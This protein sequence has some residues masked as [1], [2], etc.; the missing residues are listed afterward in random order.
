M[1]QIKDW[2]RPAGVAALA[3][4]G[5]LLALYGM[6]PARQLPPSPPAASA[7]PPLDLGQGPDAGPPTNEIGDFPQLD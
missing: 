2:K 3:L 4:L 6:A 5:I 7:S 1:H